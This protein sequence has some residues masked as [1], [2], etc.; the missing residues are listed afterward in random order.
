[1]C[2]LQRIT[3][4]DSIIN[5]IYEDNLNGKLSDERFSKMLATYE[6]EQSE[7]SVKAAVLDAELDE[8][9]KKAI[10]VKRFLRLVDEYVEVP[11]LTAAIARRFIE[12]IVVHDPTYESYRHGKKTHQKKVAQ[13]IHIHYVCIDEFVLPDEE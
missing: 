5:R 1:M 7:L 2:G 6:S 13:E 3:E 10:D 11:E 9:D 4:L 12:K 8:T